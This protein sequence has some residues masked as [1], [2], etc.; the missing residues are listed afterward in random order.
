M[1]RNKERKYFMYK[2][3]LSEIIFDRK[4]NIQFY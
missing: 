4:A 2:A 3:L 1:K